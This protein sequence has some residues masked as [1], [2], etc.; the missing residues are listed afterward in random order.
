MTP[1]SMISVVETLLQGLFTNQR[2]MKSVLDYQY[3]TIQSALDAAAVLPGQKALV[4]VYPGAVDTTNPR[5]NG[6]GAYYENLIMYSPV[7]LQGVGPGGLRNDDTIV[8]GSIIDGIA[9]GG[10]TQ[11]ATDWL[12]KIS[13]LTWDGSQDINDGQVIYVLASENQTSLPN[14]ARQFGADFKASIDGF[15]IR[16]GDQQGLP[17]NLNA[18]FGG[19]PGPIEAVQVVTQGGAIFANAFV[20]NL[21]ITNN[22]IDSNGGSYGTI[23]IGTPNLLGPDTDQHNENLRIANNRIFANGGTNLAGAIGLFNGADYY[24]IANNDLCGNFSAEYGG[25]ISHFGFSPYGRIHDNRIYFNHSYDEG[26]GIMIAG[27][28]A[29]DPAA[30][31]GAARWTSRFGSSRYLQQPDPGQHG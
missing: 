13:S 6:R 28:L 21:Q 10:D 31:Y 20:R 26:A 7:K 18:I 22:L 9:F 15:E 29:T 25:A 27:E 14:Q 5:Y 12:T 8:Q 17:G 4:V 3:A 2:Y 1:G 19:F 16:G 24:E 23:R 11:L 30:D